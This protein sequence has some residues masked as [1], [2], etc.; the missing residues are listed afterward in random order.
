MHLVLEHLRY[1]Y[2][3]GM[4]DNTQVV[5][6]LKSGKAYKILYEKNDTMS[7]ISSNIPGKKNYGVCV[8]RG[9]GQEIEMDK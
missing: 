9:K 8:C 5:I 7:S 1:C 4:N 2:L 6:F 3:L